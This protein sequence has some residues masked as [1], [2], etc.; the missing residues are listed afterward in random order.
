[1]LL[2]EITETLGISKTPEELQGNARVISISGLVAGAAR[3][4]Q[5]L[6][7]TRDRQ[8]VCSRIAVHT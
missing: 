2:Q 1:M 7:S 8:N 5:L 6:P 3:A 4:L